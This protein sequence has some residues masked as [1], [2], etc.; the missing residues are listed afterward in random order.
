MVTIITPTHCDGVEN[1]SIMTTRP[2]R[3]QPG[4]NNEGMSPVIIMSTAT[5]KFRQE[6]MTPRH[7]RTSRATCCD[8]QR[9]PVPEVKKVR[10]LCAMIMTYAVVFV[11]LL[12][13][14]DV[15]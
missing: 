8:R 14:V 9:H 7:A 5:P 11:E 1:D 2:G 13:S 4:H 15:A 12:L 6:G 3:D 10:E